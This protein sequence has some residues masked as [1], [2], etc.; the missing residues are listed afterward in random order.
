METIRDRFGKEYRITRGPKPER[1]FD[2]GSGEVGRR[3]AA[4]VQERQ[5]ADPA[6]CS[7]VH[8]DEVLRELG[9]EPTFVAQDDKGQAR[10]YASRHGILVLALERPSDLF[11]KEQALA[12][13]AS[14]VIAV[15]SAAA[16]R[17]SR[18]ALR[19]GL[20][21][22]DLAQVKTLLS[23]Y[24]V[25]DAELAEIQD[26]AEAR[27]LG[28]SIII[29]LNKQIVNWDNQAVQDEASR[30]WNRK[31]A[32]AADGFRCVCYVAAEVKKMP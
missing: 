12:L 29:E 26:L 2:I 18:D 27:A 6:N 21:S 19:T 8:H 30:D 9:I 28:R 5:E 31:A 24:G 13:E 1:D 32:Q 20:Q 14:R 25:S 10:V 11:Y 15:D 7:H 17:T 4:R 23:S 3:I 16:T 22:N